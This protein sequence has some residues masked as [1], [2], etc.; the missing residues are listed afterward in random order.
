MRVSVTVVSGSSFDV[1]KPELV[2]LSQN[3][4]SDLGSINFQGIDEGNVFINNADKIM[5]TDKNGNQVEMDIDSNRENDNSTNRIAFQG[6]SKS[7]MMSSVYRGELN[8][9]IEYF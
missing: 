2:L 6:E 1:E 7:E 4:K 3:E 8:T 9:S 5:L